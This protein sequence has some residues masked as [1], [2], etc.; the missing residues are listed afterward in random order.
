LVKNE[1]IRE[2]DIWRT[3]KKQGVVWMIMKVLVLDTSA[4]LMTPRTKNAYGTTPWISWE[5]MMEEVRLL[6]SQR[7]GLK[8]AHKDDS[9][10]E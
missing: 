5:L 9:N 1:R 2:E 4:R 3:V 8:E 6:P 7:K 10:W